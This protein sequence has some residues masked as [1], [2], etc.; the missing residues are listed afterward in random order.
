MPSTARR[1]RT[2]CLCHSTSEWCAVG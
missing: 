1:Q 2:R